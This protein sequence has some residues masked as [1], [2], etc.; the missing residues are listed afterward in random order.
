MN[1]YSQK[2]RSSFR[3]YLFICCLA[4]VFCLLGGLSYILIWWP[5]LWIADIEVERND[6]KEIAWQEIEF[7][8]KNIFLVKIDQIKQKILDRYPEIKE[9]SITRQLPNILKIEIEERKNIGVWC[10]VKENPEDIEV[11]ATST[12]EI[13]KVKREREVDKCFYFDSEGVVF[14][15]APSIKGSLIL[16]VYGTEESIKIRDKVISP[17]VIKFILT[18]KEDLPK[19]KTASSW[20]PEA[21]DFEIFSFEDLRVMTNQDWQIYFNQTYSVETQLDALRVI[22][23]K[24]VELSNIIEYIDLR[25]EGRVY[26]R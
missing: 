23:N 14:R 17:E 13:V 2:R 11:Q 6:V 12:E 21:V 9:V 19:I 18:V 7:P 16:N 25:I 4:A 1:K 26:Y 24:E 22:F 3:K 5:N 10:Q 20:L 8:Y 15:D